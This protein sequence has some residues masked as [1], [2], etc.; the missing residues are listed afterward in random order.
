MDGSSWQ[1]C[2]RAPSSRRHIEDGLEMS[3]PGL[4]PDCAAPC[5]HRR[6]VQAQGAWRAQWETL[7]L[8]HTLRNR[9]RIQPLERNNGD[10]EG[11]PDN[12]HP[13]LRRGENPDAKGE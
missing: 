4:A 6:G 9:W 11:R 7:S 2:P 13:H 12:C 1:P 10:P 5:V 3:I 8:I